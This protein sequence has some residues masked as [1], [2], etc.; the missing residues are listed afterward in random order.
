MMP[1]FIIGSTVFLK[2][3]VAV[4]SAS[5]YVNVLMNLENDTLKFH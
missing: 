4:T 2:D 3:N 5:M 1:D